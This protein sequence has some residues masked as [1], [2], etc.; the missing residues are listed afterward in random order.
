MKMTFKKIATSVMAAATLAVGATGMTANASTGTKSVT[1]SAAYG[2]CKYELYSSECNVTGTVYNN[3]SS[4]R[5][6]VEYVYTATTG[7]GT[8]YNSNSRSS[9]VSSG[10]HLSVSKNQK[11]H[12]S[13]QK[14]FLKGVLYGSTSGANVPVVETKYVSYTD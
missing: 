8:M 5:Y 11:G 14:H 13:G 4:K 2:S 1:G 9:N 12:S 6:I 7:T 10:S 3:S